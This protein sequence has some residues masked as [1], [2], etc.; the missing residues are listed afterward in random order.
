M[1]LS[2]RGFRIV[3]HSG[4]D[5]ALLPEIKFAAAL[6]ICSQDPHIILLVD[7]VVV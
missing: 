5:K 7:V 6:T 3:K 2:G 4:S 1:Q